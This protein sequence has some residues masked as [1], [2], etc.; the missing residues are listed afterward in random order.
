MQPLRYMLPSVFL[1]L[2]CSPPP[3]ISYFSVC[4]ALLSISDPELKSHYFQGDRI[5]EPK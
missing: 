3:C 5:F 4:P 1:C 2:P